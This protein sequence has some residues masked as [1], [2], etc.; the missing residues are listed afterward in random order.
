MENFIEYCLPY[1]MTVQDQLKRALY[2]IAPMVVGVY[3]IMRLGLLG[4]VLC[5]GLCYLAYRLFL[6]FNY[7]LEYSL[8]ENEISFSKIINKERRRELLKADISKTECYGP[9][10]HLPSNTPKVHSFLSNQ[11]EE[12]NYYWITLNSK[13]EK[14]CVLFQ[15]TP[16][17]LEVFAV[18]ARGKLQ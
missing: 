1:R 4:V 16:A 5:A 9:I 17:V 15:P 6:S 7:E 10:G 18:R 13:G 12:P 8:L 2:T 3:L 11:G 14:V